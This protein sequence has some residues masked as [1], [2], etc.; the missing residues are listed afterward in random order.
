V[1]L[2]LLQLLDKRGMT[3]RLPDDRRQV[4]GR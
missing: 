4:T 3:R 1:V 2:P